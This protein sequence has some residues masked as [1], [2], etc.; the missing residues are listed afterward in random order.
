MSEIAGRHILITGGASGIGRLMARKLAG[1]GG[2]ISVWD[3][4]REK[5]DKVV[6]E[7]ATAAEPARG[8]CCDISKRED[9]YRVAAETTAA[10]GVSSKKAFQPSWS[11]QLPVY[12]SPLL[13]SCKSRLEMPMS[14]QDG[15]LRRGPFHD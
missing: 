10:A 12:Q 8:F 7:L 1:L 2:R 14:L 9:V 11:A 5:L 15:A 6:A 13:A 3:I 4:D